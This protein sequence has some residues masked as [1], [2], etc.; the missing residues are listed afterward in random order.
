MNYKKFILTR[1]VGHKQT[2]EHGHRWRLYLEAN[3]NA[4]CWICEKWNY[5]L[6]FWTRRFGENDHI[7][8]TSQQLTDFNDKSRCMDLF[9]PGE[10]PMRG[11]KKKAPANLN[12]GQAPMVSSPTNNN[13]QQ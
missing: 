5:T 8:M 9:T 2:M 12:R 6:F 3:S 4:N 11:A 13:N 1:F 7:K 10:M